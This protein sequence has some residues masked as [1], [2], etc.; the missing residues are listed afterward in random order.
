[1][2]GSV[3]FA[4]YASDS[5]VVLPSSLIMKDAQERSFVFVNDNL[6]A[7][8]VI[9]SAGKSYDGQ[10][11]ILS[12]LVGGES[13]ISKGARKLVDGQDIRIANN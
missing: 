12:G 9:V 11:E 5:T 6:K 13:I 2:V 8:K 4:D 10:T 1:M 3:R 7:R